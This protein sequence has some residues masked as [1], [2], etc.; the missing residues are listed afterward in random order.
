MDPTGAIFLPLPF[1]HV[2]AFASEAGSGNASC[3]GE[4]DKHC[5]KELPTDLETTFITNV[6]QRTE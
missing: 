1:S 2:H 3:L 5:G 4:Q 6:H